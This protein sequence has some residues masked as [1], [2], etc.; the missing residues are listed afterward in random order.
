MLLYISTTPI[1]GFGR[2]P[3]RLHFGHTG[4]WRFAEMEVS[5]ACWDV[6]FQSF[7]TVIDFDL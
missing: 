6:R 4:L 1:V 3:D 5:V 2:F 7:L